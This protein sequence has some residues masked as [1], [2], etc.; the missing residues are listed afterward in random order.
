MI[1]IFPINFNHLIL[2]TSRSHHLLGN[3]FYSQL[4]S[5]L[6]HLYIICFIVSGSASSLL[7]FSLFCFFVS[8]YS[9]LI[10]LHVLFST[11]PFKFYYAIQPCVLY[12]S[13]L[14]LFSS[15]L[16]HYIDT[17]LPK[18]AYKTLIAPNTLQHSQSLRI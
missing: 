3:L 10:S 14:Y 15:L 17:F 13:F 9:L 11:V 8:F 5:K 7:S 4:T 16:Y 18:L 12:Y 6:E 1:S 2:Y